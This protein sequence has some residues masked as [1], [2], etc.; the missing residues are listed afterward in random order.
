[1]KPTDTLISQIYFV[2]KLYIFRAVTLPIITSF[3]LY[4]RHW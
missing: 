4:I 3:P 2:K 1:M